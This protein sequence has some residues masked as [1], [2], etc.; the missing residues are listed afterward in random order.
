MKSATEEVILDEQGRRQS[1]GKRH[2][3][4]AHVWRQAAATP[5][6]RTVGLRGGRAGAAVEKSFHASP[7]T[8]TRH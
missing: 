7:E 8:V 1:R 3:S 4:S 6:I 2:K 5:S